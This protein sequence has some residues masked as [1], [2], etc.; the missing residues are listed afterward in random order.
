M[1]NATSTMQPALIAG[2]SPGDNALVRWV[3]EQVSYLRSMEALKR[4]DQRTLDDIGISP[5]QFPML[6]RRHAQ[7]LPPL[8]RAGAA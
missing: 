4:L 8:V 3:R 1:Q 5:D 6:A 7:G 2:A